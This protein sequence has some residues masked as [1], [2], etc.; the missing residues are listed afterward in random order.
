MTPARPFDPACRRCPRLVDYR[1]RLQAEHPDWHC[2]P[3]PPFGE[4]GAPLL[5]VGLAPGRLGANRTGRVFTGDAS[6][7]VL[8]AG[9]HRHGLASLP[10]ARA[11]DDGLVLSGCRITNAVKCLPPG[12]RARGAEVHACNDYLRGEIDAMPATGLV[13][14]LGTVA[15]GAVL[16]ALGATIARHPFGHGRLHRPAEDRPALLDSY[17]CSRYNLQTRR[18]T[19]AMLD[20]VIARAREWIADRP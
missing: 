9:L 20:A 19:P 8:F 10:R 1:E 4:A 3:V 13:L 14:A 15:H 17:H 16:R 6:G 7:D 12:N 18:L 5:I 11:V 2:A